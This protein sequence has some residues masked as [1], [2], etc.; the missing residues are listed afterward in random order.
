MVMFLTVMISFFP[1]AMPILGVLC[2]A[3]VGYLLGV[4]FDD[5]VFDS[6][7]VDRDVLDGDDQ[8]FS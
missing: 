5:D 2:N 1:D 3:D 6:D 4:G 7:V 8:L